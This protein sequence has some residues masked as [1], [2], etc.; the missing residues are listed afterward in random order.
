MNQHQQLKI[1]QLNDQFRKGDPSLGLFSMTPKVETL[2]A[3]QKHKLLEDISK[4][5]HFINPEPKA[6]SSGEEHDFGLVSEDEIDYYWEVDYYNKDLKSSSPNPAD[7]N[8]TV[9]VLTVMRADEY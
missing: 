2:P 9:R 5:D 3:D 4:V 8:C 1:T 7:P 6:A